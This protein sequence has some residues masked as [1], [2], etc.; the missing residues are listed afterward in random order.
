MIDESGSSRDHADGS[1][2]L[3]IRAAL[4][5][6][7]LAVSNVLQQAQLHGLDSGVCEALREHAASLTS[8]AE[9][10]S[11]PHS[12]VTSTSTTRQ[13]GMVATASLRGTEL[14]SGEVDLAL[15]EVPDERKEVVR[16]SSSAS[17][18]YPSR[19][20]SSQTF[21][22]VDREIRKMALR[23]IFTDL[24]RNHKH[25]N[26]HKLREAL[27]REGVPPADLRAFEE[28]LGGNNS[29]KQFVSESAWFG[30]VDKLDDMVEDTKP[31]RTFAELRVPPVVQ[32]QATV[33]GKPRLMWYHLSFSRSCW[34]VLLTFLLLYLAFVLPFRYGFLVKE[35]GHEPFDTVD[36]CI[37]W[38]FILDI[39]VNFRTTFSDRDGVDIV[40]P[41]PVAKH[42]LKTWFV[43]DLVSSVPYDQLANGLPGLHPTKLLKTGKITKVFK[44]LR[45]ARLFK[46]NEF[47]KTLEFIIMS[48]TSRTALNVS[49]VLLSTF[50]LCHWVACFM[51][52]SGDGYLAGYVGS[53]P[54]ERYLAAFYWAMTTLT[55]VGYGDVTP[56]SNLERAYA[57]LAMV[58]GGAFY[59]Y[60]LG[61]IS[62]FVHSKNMND[63]AFADRMALV[64]AWLSYHGLPRD[65]SRRIMRHF[66]LLLK[67]KAAVDEMAIMN[68]LS[69]ELA[70]EVGEILI[71]AEIRHA[72]IFDGLQTTMLTHLTNISRQ[73]EA[74]ADTVI[75]ENGS[76]GVGMFLIRHGHVRLDHGIEDEPLQLLKPRESW[77]EEILLGLSAHYKYRVQCVSQVTLFM[78]PLDLFK[79]TF[80][81]Y[82]DVLKSMKENYA[83]KDHKDGGRP[84]M[85]KDGNGRAAVPA[86]SNGLPPRF[87]DTVL[88]Y[89]DDISQKLKWLEFE[90]ARQR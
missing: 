8:C 70:K 54:F 9:A 57:I 5:H 14:D 7:H 90:V 38:V 43:V 41:W 16:F 66:R 39:I 73:H 35:Y 55:T 17:G 11:T 48:A 87:A 40:R 58:V 62:F 49:G 71:P 25:V 13:T 22:L 52:M 10:S 89:F 69:P 32:V 3:P 42:Y 15:P 81:H 1:L 88:D 31:N 18:Y 59:G 51:A 2:N 46:S 28:V 68:D 26:I 27:T 47:Q 36:N 19:C 74:P 82:R 77:G 4:S 79:Q 23:T 44:V 83:G 20:D 80:S 76:Q 45:M 85:M 63:Q 56:A 61:N 50:V 34:D 84:S 65:T 24:R 78:V 53:E 64:R 86:G 12:R 33:G 60:I 21:S 75:V 30:A 29:N 37:D 6:V 67:Q 72:K